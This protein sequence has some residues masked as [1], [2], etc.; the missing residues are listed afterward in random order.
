MRWSAVVFGGALLMGIATGIEAADPDLVPPKLFSVR[1][2]LGN[3]LAKL[4]GDGAANIAYFGGSITAQ[5]GWR[6]KT[7]EWFRDTWPAAKVTEINAAIGGT[8]SDLGVF[9][10]GQDVLA[11][12]PDFVFVEFAVNDGGAAPD[13]IYRTM[14]G[15]VRQIWRANP[16]TDICFVYTIHKAFIPDYEKGFCNRSTTAH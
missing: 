7:L 10:C 15:I 16:E 1:G 5:A 2:G 13:S 3:V 6:V 4:K 14:E 9:R 8:G 12:K 11:H